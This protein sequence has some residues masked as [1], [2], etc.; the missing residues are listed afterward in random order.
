MQSG[1][2]LVLPGRFGLLWWGRRSCRLG[3]SAG[4]CIGRGRRLVAGGEGRGG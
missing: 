1:S 4:L 3:R 2:D